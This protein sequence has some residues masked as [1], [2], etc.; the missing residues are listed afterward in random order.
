MQEKSEDGYFWNADEKKKYADAIEYLTK[1]QTDK[2]ERVEQL[3]NALGQE[4]KSNQLFSLSKKWFTSSGIRAS[5][6][7]SG[8]LAPKWESSKQIYSSFI[9]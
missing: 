5:V 3:T 2:E 7:P 8:G 9:I 1:C 6:N 4:I